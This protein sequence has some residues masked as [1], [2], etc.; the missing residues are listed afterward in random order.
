MKPMKILGTRTAIQNALAYAYTAD[1]SMSEYLDYLCRVDKTRKTGLEQNVMA[2]QFAK[3]RAA[4]NDQKAPIPQ[5]LHYAYGP[6][7]ECIDKGN[8]KLTLGRM[9]A[10]KINFLPMTIKK[11]DRLERLCMCAVEDYRLGIFRGQRLPI[12]VYCEIMEV[13]QSHWDRDGWEKCR[14]KAMELIGNLDS[15]G[16]AKVSIT[17]REIR[18]AEEEIA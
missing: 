4:I 5:W 18:E 11:R 17:V 7:M 16:L 14:E 3:I 9:L 6:D 13:H 12:V 10:K 1:S 15:E 8:Q 2:I